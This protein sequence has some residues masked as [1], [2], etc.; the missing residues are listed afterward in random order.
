[1][2]LANVGVHLTIVSR[3]GVTVTHELSGVVLVQCSVFLR[4]IRRPHTVERNALYTDVLVRTS[5]NPAK[6]LCQLAASA[7]V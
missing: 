3:C 6:W 1:M 5:E 4:Y 7:L 2:G